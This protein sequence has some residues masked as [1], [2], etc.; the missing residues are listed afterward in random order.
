MSE[1]S[2]LIPRQKVPDLEVETLSGARWT[3]SASKPR[4]FNLLVFYRGRH[5]PVCSMYMADANKRLAEFEQRGIDVI[6]L[7]MDSAERA[8]S[9][10]D[11]WKLDALNIGY[12]LSAAQARQ[13]G[14]YLSTS[15]GKTSIGIEEPELFSEPGLFLVRPD[16]TLYWASVQTMPFARPHFAEIIKAIDFAVEKDYPARGEV[17]DSTRPA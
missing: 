12:G 5:C 11:D 17:L 6:A 14:L 1:L 3:L 13:W 10:R 4:Q 15:R 16:Q 7:S 2:P 9:A 8:A